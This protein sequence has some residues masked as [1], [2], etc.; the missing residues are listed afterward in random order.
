MDFDKVETFLRAHWPAGLIIT[1]I[2]AP[3]AWAIAS[4]HFGERIAAL[5]L[6]LS[7]LSKEVETLQELEKRRKDRF[8]ADGIRI[9]RR[10][11]TD[12][13]TPSEGVEVSQK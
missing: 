9:P 10:E 8:V 11:L 6:R 12:I 7:N 4:L 1:I 13:F 2:V 3:A 5:E